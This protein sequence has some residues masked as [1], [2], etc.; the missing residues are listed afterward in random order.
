[1]H[2]TKQLFIW[3]LSCIVSSM[4]AQKITWEKS[5]G[6]KHAE[7]LAD[8]IPTADYGFLLA[9]SSLSGKTGTK[10]QNNKGNLDFWLWKMNEHGEPEWQKSY[11]G[12]AMDLL[13]TIAPTPDGGF[14]LGGDSFSDKGADKTQPAYGQA[15]YWILKLDAAGNLEWQRTIGSEGQEQIKKILVTPDGYLIAGSSASSKAFDKTEENYGALDYWVIKTDRKGTIQWQKTFGGSYNDI[16]E[17]AIALPDGGFILGGYSNSPSDGTKTATLNGMGDF[18]VLRIDKKGELLWQKSYGGAQDDHLTVLLLKT[19][20]SLWM[21]GHSNS[22]TDNDKTTANKQ[23]TDIWLLQTDLDGVVQWQDTYN[24]GAYDLLSSIIDNKDGTYLLSGFAKGITQKK[25]ANPLL[26]STKYK[27]GTADYVALKINEKGDILWDKS[28][29]SE[30]EEVLVKTVLMRDGAYLMCGTSKAPT[31]LS[32]GKQTAAASK[33]RNTAIGSTDFWVVKLK[34][35]QKPDTPKVLIDAYPNPALSYTNIAI[36]YDYTS[37]TASVVDLSGKTL[38]R[39]DIN[40]SRTI[41]VDL[42]NYPEGIYIV[43]IKTNVQNDG[44]KI[45]K[46]SNKN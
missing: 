7:Y 31:V 23:G 20:G 15:D 45:I 29:G 2:T 4:S 30:G 9:G 21:G 34:D 16:L 11:G 26:D 43:N 18:W 8:V 22:E 39:F 24:I 33:D 5:M 40:G 41:P 28:V 36:G 38:Q 14:I 13:K 17:D 10:D 42:S 37:G 25:G 12:E 32:M 27:N 6:G 44:V 19:N 1:M 46:S 3:C 35:E